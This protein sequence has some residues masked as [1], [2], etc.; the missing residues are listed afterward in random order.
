[1]LM[2]SLYSDVWENKKSCNSIT[3]AKSEN[4]QDRFLNLVT[5]SFWGVQDFVQHAQGPR[6]IILPKL[7]FF[8]W[9]VIFLGRQ[10]SCRKFK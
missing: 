5:Y 9:Y 10:S 7:F 8:T 2:A 4:P 3:K 6:I 1:M